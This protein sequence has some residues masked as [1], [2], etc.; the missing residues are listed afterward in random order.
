[1]KR[2]DFS[3]SIMGTA[4]LAG[5]NLITTAITASRTSFLNHKMMPRIYLQ[6]GLLIPRKVLLK[7]TVPYIDFVG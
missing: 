3:P 4:Q 2:F 1:M 6:N 5:P 7:L